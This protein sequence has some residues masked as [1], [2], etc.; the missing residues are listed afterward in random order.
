MGR[1]VVVEYSS[2]FA[3]RDTHTGQ[4]RPMGDGVDTLFDADG[5]ALSPGT[6]GFCEAWAEALNADEG[7]TLAAYFPEQHREENGA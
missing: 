5:K 2:F 6:S 7:E 4:E 3:V 1:F